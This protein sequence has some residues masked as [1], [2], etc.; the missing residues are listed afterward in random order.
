MCILEGIINWLII[1][2]ASAIGK[3]HIFYDLSSSFKNVLSAFEI[4]VK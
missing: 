3:G 4:I 1:L 2:I